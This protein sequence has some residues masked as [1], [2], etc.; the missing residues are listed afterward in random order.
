MSKDLEAIA[1]AHFE[2]YCSE[3][4]YSKAS[5]DEM[6]ENVRQRWRDRARAGMETVT[7]PVL[8]ISKEDEQT[9]DSLIKRLGDSVKQR[10]A[11][12]GKLWAMHVPG[13]DDVYACE[14]KAAA[15]QRAKEHNE[16]I[17]KIELARQFGM[18]PATIEARVIEWP[19]SA[20]SHAVALLDGIAETL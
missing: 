17:R 12:D 10:I 13:P 11:D 19:H 8:P 7:V 9:V 5:W 6:P 20:E 15:E 18:E 14:S 4:F 1:K 2:Q 16:A 3:W